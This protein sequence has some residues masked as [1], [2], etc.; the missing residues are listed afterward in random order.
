MGGIGFDIRLSGKQFVPVFNNENA[1][2]TEVR[3]SL[4]Y[5]TGNNWRI[6]LGMEAGYRLSKH[7]ELYI[8]PSYQ[9]YM[10]PFY[11]PENSKGIGLFK[12]KA[13]LR[14]LF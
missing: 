13:G 14:Y 5:R 3:N 7:W 2:V 8:E 6:I 11:A 4:Q 10:K 9:Q 1:S 12:I